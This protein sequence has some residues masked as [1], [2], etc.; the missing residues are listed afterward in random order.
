MKCSFY[1]EWYNLWRTGTLTKVAFNV[2]KAEI[3]DKWGMVLSATFRACWSDRNPDYVVFRWKEKDARLSMTFRSLHRGE[4]TC[5]VFYSEAIFTNFFGSAFDQPRREILRI[6][7]MLSSFN[8]ARML[9]Y[10]KS[11]CEAGLLRITIEDQNRFF[12][13]S[14]VVGISTFFRLLPQQ[15]LA[16]RSIPRKGVF[17]IPGGAGTGKTELLLAVMASCIDRKLPV[18][19]AS[20]TNTVVD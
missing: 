5:S 8:I 15:T 1:V 12:I 20:R 11:Y 17:C 9:D 6:Y 14:D 13:N 18:L 16:L 10:H 7:P 19:V 3:D 4:A 2:K